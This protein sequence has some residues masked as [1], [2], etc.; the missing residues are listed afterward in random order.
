V[1]ALVVQ[2]QDDAPPGLLESWARR[3]G[4]ALDVL[5]PDR[6]PLPDPAEA[7]PAA[8]VVVLG[9]DAS[10]AALDAP[11][12]APEVDWLR[13]VAARLPVLGICFG[14][15]ALASAL[16]GGVRRA[17]R[18]EIGWITLDGAEPPVPRGPFFAWHEDVIDAPPGA[19]VLA[20]NAVGVQAFTAGRHLAVQ[21]HP[22]VTPRIVE[23]WAS[24]Y[25][26]ALSDAGV[27]AAALR[28]EGAAHGGAAL[29]GA[30]ALFDAFAE[31]AGLPPAV[32]V[33]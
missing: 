20:R 29:A 32:R 15:Q 12:I 14:A 24:A 19:R 21:F 4:L 27:D 5:R 17:E 1:R 18:P 33:P 23:D 7:G 30:H 11:W 22:E 10:V 6:G 9:S 3:R 16:G 28:D 26:R 2:H 25:G 13:A 8:C 31:R